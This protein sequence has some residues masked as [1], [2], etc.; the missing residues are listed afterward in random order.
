M[1]RN[2]SKFEGATVATCNIKSLF[3]KE[4]KF[5]LLA[6]KTRFSEE[7]YAEYWGDHEVMLEHSNVY[8]CN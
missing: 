3:S 7:V 6:D 2:L 4:L 5:R 8:N 1:K